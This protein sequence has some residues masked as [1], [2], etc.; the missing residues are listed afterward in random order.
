VG[1]IQ[2]GVSVDQGPVQILESESNDN[3]GVPGKKIYGITLIKYISDCPI[4]RRAR[5]G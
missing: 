1:A 3:T 4:W 5:I 2:V